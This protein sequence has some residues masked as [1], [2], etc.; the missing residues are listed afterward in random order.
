MTA[1]T[2]VRA[3]E[4]LAWPPIVDHLDRRGFAVIRSL[5]DPGECT[6]LGRLYD[7]DDG[8]RSHVV[9]ARHGF[10]QGEYRYF[11]N[12][13]PDLV[14]RLRDTLYA[15]LVPLANR[16]AERLGVDQRYPETL[17]QF[18]GQC[19][20]AGQAK[21]TPL[22][23]QYG[24]GDYNCLH[25]DLYGPLV[26]P[27]QATL[28]LSRPVDDF[29]GGEFVLTEQ[30]PRRQSRAQ[31]VSLAQGDCVLFAVNHRPEQG[32]RGAYRVAHRHGVSEVTRGQRRALGIIFHDAA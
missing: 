6:A 8:F 9:M 22:L 27:I 13:L 25:Q 7:H 19:H 18:L 28:L 23:L 16:W 26:F 5:L 1:T 3:R 29:D 31:V 17:A 20:A 11:A 30:R 21:P 12:P 4:T 32:S 24:P 15:G 10:G 2:A 14:G